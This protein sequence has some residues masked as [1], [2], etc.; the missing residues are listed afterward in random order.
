M[1]DKL[2]QKLMEAGK[3]PAMY[4]I[5]IEIDAELEP[6]MEELPELNTPSE[7]LFSYID[8]IKPIVDS[9]SPEEVMMFISEILRMKWF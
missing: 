3:D 6:E 2:L 1:N 9:S 4:W 8:Q 7:D 5:W